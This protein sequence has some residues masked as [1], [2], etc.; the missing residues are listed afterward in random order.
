MCKSFNF[1]LLPT[2]IY[3][4]K[5]GNGIEMEMEMEGSPVTIMST[6]TSTWHFG[7]FMV[8]TCLADSCF[9]HK[10]LETTLNKWQ[11]ATPARTH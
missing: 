3:A 6:V 2:R 10:L 5:A 1:S 4:D 7:L 9:P 8:C 11:V